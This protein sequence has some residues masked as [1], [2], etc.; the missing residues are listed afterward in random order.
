MLLVEKCQKSQRFSYSQDYRTSIGFFI[1]PEGG[2]RQ[3]EIY[4]E[5]STASA[6]KATVRLVDDRGSVLMQEQERFEPDQSRLT[7][8]IKHILPGTYFFEV[9]DGFFHQIKELQVPA[10]QS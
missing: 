2:S 5:L 7:Y 9:T 1:Y 3:N 4:V 6:R 10:I 8:T